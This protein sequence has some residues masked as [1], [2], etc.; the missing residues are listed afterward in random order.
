MPGVPTASA[1][2]IITRLSTV[3]FDEAVTEEG[4]ATIRIADET[5]EAIYRGM[6][7]IVAGARSI[8]LSKVSIPAAG[9]HTLRVVYP[10]GTLVKEVGTVYTTTAMSADA[11]AGR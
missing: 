10:G 11:V 7:P 3:V 4:F 6:I 2:P 8:D 1:V 9:R 5:G